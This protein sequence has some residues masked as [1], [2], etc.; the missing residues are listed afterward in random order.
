MKINFKFC[1]LLSVAAVTVVSCKKYLNTTPQDVVVPG[2]YY[3]TETEL[4]SALAGVYSYLAQDG[5]FSR[6]IPL[7]LEMSNDEGQYNNRNATVSNPAMY[8]CQSSTKIYS[9]CW[10]ALYKGINAANLLLANIDKSP[11]DST[12]KNPIKGEALF[13]RGFYYF[14]LVIHYG[15]VPLILTPSTQVT[16]PNYSRTP[17][18]Q[19]YNQILADMKAAEPLVQDITATNAPSHISKTAIE[20]IIARVYLKMAGNP[21]KLGLPMYDSAK[22]WALKVVNSGVHSLNPNYRQIFINQSQDK[23]DYKECMWEIEFY[24]NNT[25][26]GTMPPG[27]RFA[28]LMSMRYT[29]G[30]PNPMIV[31]GYGAYTPTGTLDSLYGKSPN[32]AFPSLDT[33]RRYWNIPNYSYS[34]TSNPRTTTT[35]A[36]SPWD[37]DCGKWKRDY[38][39]FVPKNRDWGPTNF[40]VLRY[41]D[42]LLMLA[43][44]YNELG[45]ASNAQLYLNQVRARAQVGING[46]ET[47]TDQAVLRQTIRDERARELCFEGLR[48]FD[49]I[50]W[51]IFYQTMKQQRDLID[52]STS[53]Y[54]SR[55]LYTYNNVSYRDTLLPIPVSEISVNN[56]MTQNPG[57]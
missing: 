35:A 49:L 52:A 15:D 48:K 7:E 26:T 29:G 46:L 41:A 39:T 43:E 13:L 38:E 51:G 22:T 9:D 12:I 6:N 34:S 55:Y 21:L 23:Y 53:S 4:R 30:D 17:S 2:N 14:Q 1:V 47:S 27:S 16:N 11:V 5:T 20:G 50:R 19:V 45:D 44:A 31:Y 40:P 18:I 42:V 33:V 37:R 54:K 10:T 3:N 57:W 36:S 28:C 56:L 25:P 8:D 24:G 32:P